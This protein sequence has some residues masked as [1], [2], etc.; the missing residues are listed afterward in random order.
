MSSLGGET[1]TEQ[2]SSVDSADKTF[3]V[4][5]SQDGIN[6]TKIYILVKILLS[7]LYT[8]ASE[9]LDSCGGKLSEKMI[10]KETRLDWR[11]GLFLLR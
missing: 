8:V 11:K 3:A 5:A 10:R 2:H 4:Q 1:C 6:C 7:N 9:L